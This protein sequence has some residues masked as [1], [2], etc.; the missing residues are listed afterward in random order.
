MRMNMKGG[1]MIRAWMKT[2][3]GDVTGCWKKD[4][5][6]P[7]RRRLMFAFCRRFR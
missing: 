6:D 3:S 4:G 2:E 7:H 1:R 5:N